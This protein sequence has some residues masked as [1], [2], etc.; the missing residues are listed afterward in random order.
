MRR[1]EFLYG[2]IASVVYVACG[3]GNP[4]EPTT[5]ASPTTPPPDGG[6]TPAP[7]TSTQE[8]SDRVFP[9]G[10]A[11]G[12][13]RPD[14]VVL[15]TRVEPASVGRAESDDIDVS[16]VVARDEALTD[17]VA[18]GTVTATASADHTVRLVPT[19]LAAGTRYF[20][21]FAASGTTTQVG[22]T[23]T[24]PARDADVPVLFAVASC[25]DFIGRYYH[26]WR[27]LLEE[28]ADLDFVLFL[29]D[30]IYESVNDKRFQATPSPDRQI[31]LPDGADVSPA[32]DRSRIVA[33]T[34]ADY[35]FLYKTYRSDALLKEVHRR[36]P[37]VTTWDDHEFAND[38]WQDHSTYFNELDPVTKQFTDEKNTPRRTAADRA[39]F[40][41]L[42]L[43]VRYTPNAS[44]PDDIQVYRQLEWG[45]HVD[46]FVT[47]ERYYRSDHVI[48]EGPPN[49]AVGKPTANSSVGSRYFVRRDGFDP[50]EAAA[51]PTMLG[52]TQKAWLVGAVTAS[53]ATWKVWANEVQ[54]YQMAADLGNLPLV[55]PLL[56]YGAY[57]STDQWDG[58]RTERAEIL[59]AFQRAN[60]S[61]LLVCTG[62]IHSFWAAEL[63]VDFDA[64]GPKPVGVE[65][66][67]A[68]ISSSS[69]QSVLSSYILADSPLSP[70]ADA[71]T[72][73][74][75]RAIL[76]S[77]PHLKY[78]DA[79]SYGFVLVAIDAT[80]ADVTFVEVGAPTDPTY[81]GVI[82]RKQFR[83]VAGT[84]T[85]TSL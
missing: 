80:K 9:Q 45:R 61:N 37:F 54:M 72:N 31:T 30:Y 75:D 24:A 74:L 79:D 47:D 81:R 29:G 1:R 73:V 78:A 69:L 52:N 58:Y 68:G 21:R 83:T 42:P 56:N 53:T 70:I 10:V 11:S 17:V 57:V 41:Y 20:Y 82:G 18:S 38:C 3:Q 48:P 25:Q 67:G 84:S 40:E 63:H 35:R 12:D 43:D 32:Q 46:L 59:G 15:W 60:V 49:L 13:P 44:F 19:G 4:S 8:A 50:I 28:Q 55:P 22:R 36:W 39:F 65:Y 33:A 23:K 71:L 16:F 14:R 34:L 62:D 51:K 77:N 5:G 66:V 7:G 2:T 27:A 26:S 76:Q 6:G 85:I 64:P